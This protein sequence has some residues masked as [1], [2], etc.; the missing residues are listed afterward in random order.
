VIEFG[1]KESTSTSM[2]LSLRHPAPASDGKTED[3]DTENTI[4]KP[5]KRRLLMLYCLGFPL[6]REGK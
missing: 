1:H 6:I 3:A 5:A 2:D 4:G